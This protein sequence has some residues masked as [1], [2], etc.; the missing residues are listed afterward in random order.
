MNRLLA[1]LAAL[2][3]AAL[4]ATPA[5]AQGIAAQSPQ[6][7]TQAVGQFVRQQTAGMPGKVNFTVGAIDPRVLLPACNALEVFQP[8]GARLW[9]QSTVGVRCNGSATWTIYV[10]VDVK[11]TGEYLV[12][13][14]ALSPGQTLDAGDV[15][16]QH[17]ELTL[18]PTGFLADMDKALGRIAVT[19]IGAGQPLRFDQLRAPLAVQQ[20]QTVKLLTV[21]A[22]FRVTGEGRALTNAQDGQLAQVRTPSGQTING[23]ARTGGTVEIS[24]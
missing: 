1:A 10:T 20:G 9:G 15:A 8:A 23:V 3:C 7:I 24:F 19:P 5:A 12:A 4:A 21:G 16:L 18:L 2:L 22:G 17:G 14:R 11:I 13:T 6:A